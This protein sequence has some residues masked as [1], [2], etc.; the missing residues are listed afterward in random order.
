M[1]KPFLFNLKVPSK[2]STVK[3]KAKKATIVSGSASVEPDLAPPAVDDEFATILNSLH[4]LS[5][6]KKDGADLP[7]PVDQLLTAIDADFD[8][9][10]F[11]NDAFPTAPNIIEW[12]RGREYLNSSVLPFPKQFQTL[13]HFNQDACYFCSDLEF[14][15]DMPIEATMGEMLD[16]TAL[17]EYGVCPVCRRNRIEI[18]HEWIVDPRFFT[19]H[20]YEPS[21]VIKPTQY[22]ELCAVWG[23]RAG[24]SLVASTFS[25]TY[26]IHRYLGLPDPMRYYGE[27]ANKVI[28]GTFVAPIIPQVNT[29]L[30]TPF[31]QAMGSSPWYKE[32]V[33]HYKYEGKRLGVKLIRSGST[34]MLFVAKRLA[35]HMAAAN[36]STLRGGTRTWYCIGGN[37]LINTSKGLIPIKHPLEGRACVGNKSYQITNQVRVGRRVVQKIILEKGYSI[38]TTL[39]HHIKVLT[40][41][42]QEDWKRARE[43]SIGD[44]VAVNLGTTFPKQLA[45]NYVPMCPPKRRLGL[46]KLIAKL[47]TFIAPDLFEATGLKGIYTFTHRLIKRG[48]L[49]KI[50]LT[51]R[52]RH[53]RCQYNITDAF[54]LSLIEEELANHKFRDRDTVTFPTKMTPELGYLLGYYV[55]E[56]AYVDGA[57]EFSFSNT[58]KKVV[59]HFIKCFEKVFSITPRT[60]RSWPRRGKLLYGVLIAYN[61]VKNFLR[62]VGLEPSVSLTKKVPWSILQAPREAVLAFLS[63]Y[64]E[65]DGCISNGSVKMA[66]ISKQLLSQIQILLLNLGIVSVLDTS[67]AKVPKNQHRAYCLRLNHYDSIRLVAQLTCPTKGKKFN[68]KRG[69]H[70]NKDYQI[71][72]LGSYTDTSQFGGSTKKYAYVLGDLNKSSYDNYTL[73]RLKLENPSL[74]KRAARLVDTG[75]FWLPVVT[76]KRLGVKPVYDITVSSKDHAFSANGIVVH[77]SYD[78]L[79]WSNYDQNGT[80]RTNSKSGEEVFTSLNNSTSTLRAA[81]NSRWRAGDYNALQAIGVNISSPSSK[82]D[83]I[84]QRATASEKNQRIYYTHYSTFEVNPKENEE[85]KKEEYANDLERLLRDWYAIPPDAASPFFSDK[86]VLENRTFTKDDVPTPFAYDITKVEDPAS[87]LSMLNPTLKDIKA[88]KIYPRI[89]TVDN[90]ENHNSFALCL[91]RYLP[92]ID[93]IVFEELMEVA[94]Y[95]GRVVNL[96]WCHN[97]V[98]L[99]LVDLFNVL[100]VGYD[101]WNSGYS[102][103]DLRINKKVTAERYSLKW[104]DFVAFKEDL[105]GENIWFSPPEPGVTIEDLLKMNDLSM[106]SRFPRVN[107]KAQ[108]VTVNEFGRKLL[109]PDHGNDDLFRCAVLAHRLLAKYRKEF[110][111]QA[112][113]VR[114]H[115]PRATKVGVMRSNF[116]VP[117]LFRLP[118]SVY[119][120]GFDYNAALGRPSRATSSRGRA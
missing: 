107:L 3:K 40:P 52:D 26:H 27:P 60:N 99:K 31:I 7:N 110:K 1:K 58:N 71:P 24:K 90:G 63:A 19:Y 101:R 97:E 69:M 83:P 59:K 75:I 13:V 25:A 104:Q 56:G 76:L 36:S 65:G 68:F 81:A 94:P 93:G 42:L 119:G 18:Q 70:F 116:A 103:Y 14:L 62:Y 51:N 115:N 2:A 39:N 44:Y 17:L 72:F 49:R 57:T 35:L 12:C 33:D 108:I 5:F 92:E 117:G 29:Y 79:G 96:A 11:G 38:I 34:F 105:L 45:L 87:N 47:K 46:Y 80:K 64:I 82:H 89:L 30:W 61:V 67:N 6:A 23:Q 54:D 66:S 100:V 78:E 48:M 37:S 111:E 98:V 16:R 32:V 112:R 84:M 50:F 9:S 74:Y 43:L 15:F 86:R 85:D 77:N 53:A 20:S 91:G 118:K 114:A 55:S 4:T 109:K 106:R 73:K 120:G 28:E 41:D 8:L 113:H 95:G 21:L 102:F 88:D 22:N 10:V